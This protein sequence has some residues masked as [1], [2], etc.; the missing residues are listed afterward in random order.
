M[1]DAREQKMSEGFYCIL[2]PLRD[3]RYEVWIDENPYR[4]IATDVALGDWD[5]I[6]VGSSWTNSRRVGSYLTRRRSLVAAAKAIRRARRNRK[7]YEVETRKARANL[8]RERITISE[9]NL[10]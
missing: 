5:R 8:D 2:D 4:G 3:G 9:S 10:V 6:R 7:R 1:N